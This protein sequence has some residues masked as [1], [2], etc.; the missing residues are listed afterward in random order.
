MSGAPRTRRPESRIQLSPLVTQSRLSW[1][2]S[3][4][5]GFYVHAS[6]AW[7]HHRA[8]APS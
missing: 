6:Q 7:A 1:Q 4:N 2:G 3:R 5:L 8:A